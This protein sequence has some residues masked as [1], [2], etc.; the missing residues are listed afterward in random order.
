M[1]EKTLLQI[2]AV[3]ANQSKGKVGSRVPG[4]CWSP[5]GHKH[6]AWT[7][8]CKV[9]KVSPATTDSVWKKPKQSAYHGQL[10][11]LLSQNKLEATKIIP[12]YKQNVGVHS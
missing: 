1:P 12:F 11:C 2:S 7:L 5:H 8:S 3:G 6:S 10:F 9:V 4:L